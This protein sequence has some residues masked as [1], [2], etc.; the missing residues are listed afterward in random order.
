[1]SHT[2]TPKERAARHEDA[3]FLADNG[4]GLTEAAHRLGLTTSG[5]EKW[6]R[7]HDRQLLQQL[8]RNEPTLYPERRAA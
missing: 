3:T 6:L 5:L 4:V 1:M 2:L 8:T 7:D